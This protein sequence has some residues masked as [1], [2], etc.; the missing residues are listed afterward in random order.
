MVVAVG[1]F[2][3]T[4]DSSM[5]NVALPSIM[6][7]FQSPLNRTEWVVLVYLLTITATLLFW[8]N[9]SDKIGRRKIYSLG[10]LAFAF[11]SLACAYAPSLSW[12][13]T[14][15]FT[16]AIGAAMMMSTGPAII[17]ETFPPYQ[18]GRSLGLI[19]VAVSLGLMTG[20]SVGGFLIHFYSW[21][22]IFFITVPI[23]LLFSLLARFILY[24]PQTP[25]PLRGFDWFGAGFWAVSLTLASL[26]ISHATSPV[27]SIYTIAIM[28]MAFFVCMIIFIL[29][30]N[31]APQPLLPLNFFKQR[32]FS[33][34]ILSAMLSF[35]VLFT[36][37]MLTPFY[38]DRVLN[39][40]AAGIGLV[41]MAIPVSVMVVAPLAGWLYDQ[42]GAKLLTTTGL[43][44]TAGGLWFLSGI[45]ATSR[46]FDISWRLAL[47]GCGQALFLSPNSA[48]V[49]SHVKK[50]HNGISAAMLATARNLGMM[51]GVAMSSLIFS[52]YFNKLTNGLD[53]KEFTPAHIG[54]FM[55]ALKNAF[56]FAAG[57]GVVGAI[58]SF[59]RKGKSD[60]RSPLEGEKH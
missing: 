22:A 33:V 13:I 34:G 49:L 38:L 54:P 51:V 40:N 29:L 25:S 56:I 30:E 60:M 28:I 14:S 36:A 10:L 45:S 5:V 27:W 2:M 18:L 9:L 7:D 44:L 19:G 35:S 37:V 46:P 32:F 52:L 42:V 24:A 11:G 16:Q 4:L 55:T 48:S 17:K 58:I 41:M 3:S 20:P 59:M 6:D 47:T 23:G 21:R 50:K 53:M 8:G 1:V 31:K 43:L 39:L 15:R 12:L 57:V 26:A